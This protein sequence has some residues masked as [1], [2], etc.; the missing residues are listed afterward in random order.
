MNIEFWPD[1]VWRAWIAGALIALVAGPM[2]CLVV[3]Q[4]MAYFGHTLS[5]SA[6][7]GV[8]IGLTFGLSI[9]VG[10][11]LVCIAVGSLLVLLQSKTLAANRWLPNDTL[12]GIMSHS[13]LALGV[14]LLALQPNWRVNLNSYLFGDILL[15]SWHDLISVAIVVFIALAGLWWIWNRVL[16]I[17]VNADVAQ[18]E[19]VA[20]QRVRFI[21]M[22][23]LGLV[24]ALGMKLVGILM[25]ASLLI[26]P[27]A[28]ARP[29]TKSPESMAILAGIFALLAV[30]LGLVLSWY[31]D[32]PAGSAIVVVSAIGFLCALPFGRKQF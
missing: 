19:G 14:L 2:G 16:A 32:V 29:F 9:D 1:F 31:T 27:A 4:R 23:L 30:S 24:M 7:L 18:I 26:V 25:I 20:V 3:W 13:L 8:V 10:I 12:L 21:M 28:S 22:V 11:F 6:L 5:H 15:V 17:A